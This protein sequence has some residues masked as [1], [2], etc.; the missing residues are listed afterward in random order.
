MP[1]GA[2]QIRLTCGCCCH[3]SPWSVRG[4]RL[5]ASTQVRPVL[6]R[7]R[8]ASR[9]VKGALSS[10]LIEMSRPSPTDPSRGTE[11]GTFPGVEQ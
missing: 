6:P 5:A 7:S 10:L 8:T 4:A 2:S 9:Y 11:R 3:G 1:R